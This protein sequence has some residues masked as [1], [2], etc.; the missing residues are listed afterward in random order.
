MIDSEPPIT[1]H[2]HCILRLIHR[3]LLSCITLVTY[4][5]CIVDV[6]I[7]FRTHTVITGLKVAIAVPAISNHLA[8]CLMRHNK[9][10]TFSW[11]LVSLYVNI[12]LLHHKY[13]LLLSGHTQ[14]ANWLAFDRMQP[15]IDLISAGSVVLSLKFD[16][17]LMGCR[18]VVM[19]LWPVGAS[20]G[21]VQNDL[22]RY[23]G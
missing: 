8:T 17:Q 4:D 22:F 19:A 21:R 9:C 13:L 12:T 15:E 1:I 2:Q 11:R 6:L 14:R 10:M 18:S 7:L 3:C 16:W 5:Y 20:G 23:R